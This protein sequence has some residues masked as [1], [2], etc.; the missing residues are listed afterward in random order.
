MISRDIVVKALRICADGSK[1]CADC[2][3]CDMPECPL[4]L[5]ISAAELLASDGN[6]ISE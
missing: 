3:L 1:S 5:L 4:D 2:P 6:D